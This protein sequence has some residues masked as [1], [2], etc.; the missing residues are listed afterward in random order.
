MSKFLKVFTPALLGT[1]GV[2]A[3]AHAASDMFVAELN[4]PVESGFVAVANA[5]EAQPEADAAEPQPMQVAAA[6]N[7]APSR[8][9]G[10]GVGREALPEEIDAWN[11]DVRP[12]GQ[13]LPKGKG[14]VFTGEEV[15][16]EKCAVCH[17]DFGEAVGRWPQLAGGF[18][19]LD[20]R[21]PVK[22]VGSYWPYLSTVWDYVHRAM[23]FGDAQS[24]TNDEVYAI[25]AY[26]LYL[27]NIVEDDF[28]LSDANFTDIQ[29]PNEEGFKP[30]DRPETELPQFSQ[31]ACMEN[32]KDSVE[33]TM[34]AAILDVTPGTTDDN[35]DAGSDGA[36]SEAPATEAP[37]DAAT[38]DEASA[39]PAAEEPKASEMAAAEVA[40]PTPGA[41]AA[42]GA[43]EAD[44]G[45]AAAP[46]PELVA[47]GEKLFKRCQA[48]HQIGDNAKNRSGPVLNGVVGR[49]AGTFDDFRYSSAIKD[50]GGEGLVWN[51]ETLSAFL[52]DPRGYI[53][54]N[55]MSFP[56]LKSDED[57]AAMVAFLKSHSQ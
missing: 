8:D 7:P 51:E 9:G 39:A 27:N 22:T 49:T 47:S 56:G 42:D 30:D 33:I 2:L 32:C 18:E 20:R 31:D 5:Q 54:G 45:D 25:T 50:A 14:D 34:R 13:G 17:G 35:E 40:E 1:A 6:E 4:A 28:E 46:D 23:P 29:M 48:C 44:A 19:T 3:V 43:A 24:L 15:F 12:D 57:I 21:D 26:L 53:K 41:T 11:I 37:A 36:A 10:F 16:V 52:A 55:K 38:Q